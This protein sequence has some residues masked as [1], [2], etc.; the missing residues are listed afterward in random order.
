MFN[1]KKV[2]SYKCSW[3]SFLSRSPQVG[4]G[5]CVCNPLK[6]HAFQY[7]HPAS[8]NFYHTHTHDS[9]TVHLNKGVYKDPVIRKLLMRTSFS[10]TL[11]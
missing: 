3:R 4:M 8:L 5:L 7:R 10:G 11:M 9:L 2:G 1:H 6:G